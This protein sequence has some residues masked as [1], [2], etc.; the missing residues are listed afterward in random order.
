MKVLEIICQCSCTLGNLWLALL[1]PTHKMQVVKM[2]LISYFY[3]ILHLIHYVPLRNVVCVCEVR[4]LCV[5]YKDISKNSMFFCAAL[6]LQE[7]LILTGHHPLKQQSIYSSSNKHSRACLFV[8]CCFKYLTIS[9]PGVFP[10][11][12]P[13]QFLAFSAVTF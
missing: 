1:L 6:P 7:L 8:I 3:F 9:I 11:S 5:V 12:C 4:L 2:N 13:S 10:P